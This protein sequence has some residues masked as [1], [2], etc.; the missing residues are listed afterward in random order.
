MEICL[1]TRPL[2]STKPTETSS[3]LAL[4]DRC[5]RQDA[6]AF[7]R[8]MDLYQSR[9]LGFVRRMAP[10]AED[11]LDITQDVFIRAFQSFANFDGRSAVKTWL[12]RIAYNL[13]VD[14]AR[15]Q[16]RT[17]PV[18]SLGEPGEPDSIEVS[19]T[20]WEPEQAALNVEM[21]EAVEKAIGSMSDKLRSVLLLHDREDLA[22]EEISEMLGIPVGTVKS[23]LFLARQFLQSE[24]A[25]YLRGELGRQTE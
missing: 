5:R 11:A 15:K 7:G 18:A 21:N 4:I 22:Y 2:S 8:F 17:P 20:R 12:F 3:E 14:R 13:C 9:V 25:P 24:L 19:D 16:G 6:E 10:Q 1:R 23:R